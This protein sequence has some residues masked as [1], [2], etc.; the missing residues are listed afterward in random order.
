MLPRAGACGIQEVMSNPLEMGVKSSWS[1]DMS[2]G[3]LWEQHVLTTEPSLQ[4]LNLFL[5]VMSEW[6]GV[7]YSFVGKSLQLTGL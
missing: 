6:H 4:P 1:C 7:E 2:V 3:P 5:Q